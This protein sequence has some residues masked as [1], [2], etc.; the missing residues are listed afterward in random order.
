MMDHADNR[1]SVRSAFDPQQYDAVSIAIHWSTLVL[2]VILFGAIWAREQASD[3]DTAAALLTLHRSAGTL[4]WIVTLARLLWKAT[5]ARVP[6]LPRQMPRLQRWA[7]RANENA[8]YLL[9]TLQPVTGFVQ[10]IAR[11]KGFSLLG[12]SI[13]AALAR[14]KALTQIFHDIHETTATTLLVLVGL[15]ACAALSH[16]LLL[17][18]GVLSTMLPRWKRIDVY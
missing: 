16:G 14:D 17:R 1:H 10:S 3:G 4:L 12:V 9:L 13:P 5:A 7:G 8:L 15:H 11:G 18:D 2:L 6:T